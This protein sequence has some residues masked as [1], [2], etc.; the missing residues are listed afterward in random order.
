MISANPLTDI[1]WN[2]LTNIPADILA[3]VSLRGPI[4]PG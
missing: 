3:K 4:V 2:V 1:V